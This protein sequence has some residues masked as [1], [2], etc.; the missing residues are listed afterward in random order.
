MQLRPRIYS[1]PVKKKISA[2]RVRAFVT[3]CMLASLTNSDRNWRMMMGPLLENIWSGNFI[4]IFFIKSFTLSVKHEN[5]NSVVWTEWY[6]QYDSTGVYKLFV[7]QSSFLPG[8]LDCGFFVHLI[9]VFQ[10]YGS[11]F[12][13]ND[14]VSQV[15]LPSKQKYRSQALELV[16]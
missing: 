2:M 5:P 10:I 1:V 12:R 8:N 6:D 13:K 15:C 4:L 11:F 14:N 3:A 16:H 7:G 9:M